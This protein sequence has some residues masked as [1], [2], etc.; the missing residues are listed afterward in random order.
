MENGV[1]NVARLL[2]PQEFQVRVCCLKCAGQFAARLPGRVTVHSLDKRPGFSL[3][4]AFRLARV[5]AKI[6]PD[7]LHTHN[8]GPL[9]YGSLQSFNTSFYP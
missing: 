2:D 8:L 1:V 3:G 7:I 9:F 6:K 4:T 5:M